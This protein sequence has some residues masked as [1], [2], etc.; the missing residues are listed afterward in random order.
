MRDINNFS[1]PINKTASLVVSQ[2][3]DDDIQL[4]EQD[5][6][7]LI[8]AL[9]Y[10]EEIQLSKE[11]DSQRKI[12]LIRSELKKIKR[13][14]KTIKSNLNE[15]MPHYIVKVCRDRFREDEWKSII[16]QARHEY[17]KDLKCVE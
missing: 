2:S 15:G 16:C 1:T 17:N 5:R 13:K 3:S 9:E 4:L 14:I 7:S 11:H 12:R 8:K 6:K 10:W